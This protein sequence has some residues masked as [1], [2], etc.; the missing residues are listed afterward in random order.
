MLKK[1]IFILGDSTSMTVGCEN[2][3]YPYFLATANVW[4]EE[5]KINNYSLAGNT[6]SDIASL[7]FN[8]IKYKVN[9]GDIIIIFLGNC[10][11]ASREITK[12]KYDFYQHIINKTRS[13][14]GL[15]Q[16]KTRL[17][18][19]LHYFSWNN[20][21]N[22]AIEKSVSGNVFKYNI[23]KIIKF[24]K[25]KKI[26]VILIK[27][28]AN[29]NFFPG[30]GKGNFIFYKYLGLNERISR[31]LEIEDIHFLKAL[32]EHENLNFNKA[33]EGY[34]K[35]LLSNNELK[36][37]QEYPI[38]VANNIA[39][40]KAQKRLFLEAEYILN[41]LLKENYA[42]KEII[43]Y[44]LSQISYL[45]NNNTEYLKYKKLSYENDTSLYRIRQKYKNKLEEIKK[46]N[47]EVDYIN[48]SQMIKQ[49]HFIDHCH[50]IPEGQ[51]MLAD[52]ILK[53]IKNKDFKGNKKARIENKLYNPELFKGNFQKFDVY[54]KTFSSISDNQ[55]KSLVNE[56]LIENEKK[57]NDIKL[58]AISH[59]NSELESAIKY[60]AKHPI[61][62]SLADLKINPPEIRSDI[63]RFPEYFLVRVII[64][65]IVEIENNGD[66]KKFFNH[67]IFRSSNNLKNIL[68]SE[69]I[70]KIS[71][72]PKELNSSKD[73]TRFN[74]IIKK[75]RSL[76]LGHLEE[77]SQIFERKKTTIFWY[78]RETL[79]FGS[80]SRV[81]MLY[82]RVLLEYLAEALIVAFLIDKK[83]NLKKSKV[84]IKIIN[85]LKKT[86]DTHQKFCFLI[87]KNDYR[88]T[89]IE[90]YSITL[91]K[92]KKLF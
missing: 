16:K 41:L 32:K 91:K 43:Y 33:I 44:N 23:T 70:E 72:Y 74:R 53:K 15:N 57:I 88:S 3:M 19:K 60:Y 90:K 36:M 56:V 9:Q 30:V 92:L 83:W 69:S 52:A 54:Y 87:H 47:R 50:P 59:Q 28:N 40:V 86:V 73:L 79:R 77:G 48:M 45:K 49:S 85:N 65:Y 11:A 51:K 67:D 21:F 89:D 76:L 7:F 39:V 6:S 29:E 4:S 20:T 8:K 63:G 42:R 13:K 37:S 71:P 62:E 78:F 34:E 12:G 25:K 24:C 55:I 66:F 58:N 75:S 64:P 14:L 81:S 84:V 5:V 46:E 2:Q 31:K 18:N 17:K 35:I 82:D 27:A 22:P 68:P 10:D 61:F 1:N 26:K 38:L 80:H